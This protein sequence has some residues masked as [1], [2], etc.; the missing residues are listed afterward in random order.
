VIAP[1]VTLDPTL[2]LALIGDGM[3]GPVRVEH[4]GEELGTDQL[5]LNVVYFAAG[6]RTRPHFHNS[7]QVL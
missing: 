6:A 3:T 2:P 5:Y 4:L 1:T 7:D